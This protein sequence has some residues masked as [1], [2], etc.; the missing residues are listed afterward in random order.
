M[1]NVVGA[2]EAKKHFSELLEK[3]HAG[4]E[5][6]ITKHGTPVA[7]LVPVKRKASA[8]DRAAAVARIRK[9]SVGLS[10]KRAKI[11]NLIA[12]GRK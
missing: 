12:E 11:R 3:V 2:C 9:L 10:L 4:D 7:K 6:T 5:I 1:S 8:E